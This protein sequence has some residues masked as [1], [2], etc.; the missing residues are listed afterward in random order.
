MITLPIRTKAVCVH[1]PKEP[2]LQQAWGTSGVYPQWGLVRSSAGPFTRTAVTVANA[3]SITT[4][5]HDALYML[6]RRVPKFLTH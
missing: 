1:A 5:N 6:Y 4:R 2:G 3:G